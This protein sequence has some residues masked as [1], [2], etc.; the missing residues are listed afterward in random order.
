MKIETVVFSLFLGLTLAEIKIEIPNK[1]KNG[2]EVFVNCQISSDQN[3]KSVKWFFDEDLKQT[4]ILKGE[5]NAT[6]N[7]KFTPK[8]RDNGKWIKCI[9][10]GENGEV[11]QNSIQ[12]FLEE[13]KEAGVAL[14]LITVLVLMS[15]FVLFIAAYIAY[16][17]MYRPLPLIEPNSQNYQ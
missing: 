1:I 15:F 2:V 8:L 4:K 9:F 6:E 5:K 10:E 13:V 17:R 16:K 14:W 7:F 3:L 12:I 11:G